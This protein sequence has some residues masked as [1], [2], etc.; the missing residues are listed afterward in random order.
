MEPLDQL[1]E[2]IERSR[3]ALFCG[4]GISYNSG[5]PL[6]DAIK[7]EILTLLKLL[8]DDA[9][10]IRNSKI[11][12]ELFME[13]LIENSKHQGLI[14]LFELGEPNQTHR[15]IAKLVK[16]GLVKQVITTNF[17][18][19]LE[20]AFSDENVVYDLIYQ[21]SEFD[22]ID[23]ED[24]RIKL[25]KIHGSIHDRSNVAITIK[26][27]SGKDL[28]YHRNK[29][30]H[31]LMNNSVTD[32]ILFLGYSFSDIFDINP[33]FQYAHEKNRMIFSV[34]HEPDRS[35]PEPFYPIK[36]KPAQNPFD[37]YPGFFTRAK[38]EDFISHC[39]VHLWKGDPPVHTK[40]NIIWKPI[41]ANWL[42]E[43]KRLSGQAMN[44]Y[45]AGQLLQNATHFDRAID[46]LQKGLVIA[47][48][49]G[50]DELVTDFLYAIG[51]C[52]QSMRRSEES[53]NLS[54]EYLEMA[55]KRCKADQLRKQCVIQLSMGV[56][57]GELE[58]FEQAIH[59]YTQSFRLA[60]E[61][62]ERSIAAICLGNIAIILKNM[63]GKPITS[64]SFLY[65]V[66]LV[67]QYQALIASI[68]EGDKR[69]EGRTNGNIGQLLSKLGQKELALEYSH[70]A[71]VIAQALSDKYHEGIW[72]NN[73]GEDMVGSDDIAAREYLLKASEIF[74]DYRWD[75]FLQVSQDIL[76][77]IPEK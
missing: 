3:T 2:S 51:R 26:R 37:A 11:P 59:Y 49:T 75:D 56:I 77:T 33:T 68:Q 76:A 57:N 44:F 58:K 54:F 46:Y 7:L 69:S 6:V 5:V 32:Q 1:Y 22:K 35:F 15:F 9:Q 40:N 72:L 8:P 34:D 65:Q 73:I 29:V 52:Y 50:E 66:A 42:N 16:A 47:E 38:T 13:C 19:L 53:R 23:W 12:F 41:I 61:L 14:D 62:S 30:L 28:V 67:L 64:L 25:V 18:H 63:V 10:L 71:L 21:E 24:R 17:D 39:S 60:N 45:L 48:S 55:F 20:D 36:D 43:V 4:A 31:G 27:V 70:K 74:R